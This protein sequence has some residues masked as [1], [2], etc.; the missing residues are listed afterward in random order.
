MINDNRCNML[1]ILTLHNY[2]GKRFIWV[3]R[4]GVTSLPH[5][6]K[7]HFNYAN[8][9]K[10]D[11]QTEQSIVHYKEVIRYNQNMSV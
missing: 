2:F 7:V 5:N 9:L 11:G 1:L 6:A 3:Y 10:D 4:S 8:L